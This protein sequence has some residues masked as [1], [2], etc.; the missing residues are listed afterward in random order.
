MVCSILLYYYSFF[1]T[2]L[3][4]KIICENQDKIYKE[5]SF[6]CEEEEEEI[7]P[8]PTVEGLP[9][10]CKEIASSFMTHKAAKIQDHIMSDRVILLFT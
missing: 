9:N 3:F 8:E 4:R 5:D 6:D 7:L 10:L 1:V 2:H